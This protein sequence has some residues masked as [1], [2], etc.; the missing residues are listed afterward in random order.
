MSEARRL[1]ERLVERIELDDHHINDS[2]VT[3]QARAYLA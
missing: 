2:Q 1:L 3:K